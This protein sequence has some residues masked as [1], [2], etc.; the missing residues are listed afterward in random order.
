MRSAS[1][2]VFR[3]LSPL[4]GGCLDSRKLRRALVAGA[5]WGGAVGIGLSIATGGTVGDILTAGAWGLAFGTWFMV[6]LAALLAR[7]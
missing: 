6:P 4:P 1:E 7:D 3:D 2:P 5:I